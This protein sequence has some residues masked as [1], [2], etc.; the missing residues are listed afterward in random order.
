MK[1]LITAIEGEKEK[2]KSNSSWAA[3]RALSIIYG[4]G[5]Q[6]IK[7]SYVTCVNNNGRIFVSE[8][9][10]ISHTRILLNIIITLEVEVAI[11]ASWEMHKNRDLT[12]A[13]FATLGQL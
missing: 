9:L 2:E 12:T 10:R 6:M 4:S 11:Y 5:I 1:R 13:H 7:R 8:L 3:S